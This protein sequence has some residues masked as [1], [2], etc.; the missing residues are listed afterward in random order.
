MRKKSKIILT[1]V[2]V[3]LVAVAGTVGY[4][5]DKQPTRAKKTISVTDAQL[6][7]SREVFLTAHRGFSAIAPENTLPAIEEAGKAGF[8][9]VEFDIF[10]TADGIWIAMH[11]ETVNRMTNGRGKV[12][13]YTYSQLQEFVIDNGANYKHYEKLQIPTLEEVLDV[14]MQYNIRPMIE[15][16]D[17]S[18]DSLDKI[19]TALQ[20]RGQLDDAIVI[21]FNHEIL[22]RVQILLEAWAVEE[23]EPETQLWYLVGDLSEEGKLA[24]CLSQPS[25]YVAFNANQKNN[26]DAV[27]TEYRDAGL[28]LACWTVDDLAV[29]ERMVNTHGIVYFTSN[30]ICPY[31]YQPE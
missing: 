1:V 24:L 17:G 26:T 20:V 2:L 5:Y 16:K 11:D 30:V 3:V 6:T 8:F 27:I 29:L 4:L 19:L 22:E 13:E 28:S 18:P 31:Q 7:P 10:E 23:D 15:V 12:A 21:S 9:A 14:C 25:W